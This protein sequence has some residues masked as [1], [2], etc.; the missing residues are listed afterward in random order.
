MFIYITDCSIISKNISS[1]C[2]HN[3]YSDGAVDLDLLVAAGTA[4]H[5]SYSNPAEHIMS[6]LNI[7]MQNDALQCRSISDEYENC[8]KSLKTMT[9]FR[10]AAER[11]DMLETAL[12]ESTKPVIVVEKQIFAFE[13]ETTAAE[14]HDSKCQ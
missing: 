6:L 4:R 9:S 11:S 2:V 3:L 5:H 13:M 8:F 14:T 10:R 1:K 7:D 12:S